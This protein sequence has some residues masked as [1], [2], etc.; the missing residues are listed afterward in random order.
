LTNTTEERGRSTIPLQRSRCFGS[1]GNMGRLLAVCLLLAA[2]SYAR[3]QDQEHQLL[4]RLLKPDMS[5]QNSAQNKKFIAVNGASFDKH[6]T[7]STFYVEKKS[8]SKRFS[9]PRDFSTWQFNAR[10]FHGGDNAA[11]FSLQKQIAH[12]K[13][14]F[15]TQ[16]ARSLGH[17]QET[18]RTVEVRT[19]AGNRPFL[20]QGKSQRSL[21]RQNPPLTIEQVRELLNK[22]K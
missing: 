2:L 4:N 14:R 18:G 1:F 6:A 17:A 5:L 3:G 22:N 7:T 19:F 21:N 13:R 16:T 20:D 10:S 12:S 9:G 11:K 8:N 15:S